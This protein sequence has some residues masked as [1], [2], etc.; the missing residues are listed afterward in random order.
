MSQSTTLTTTVGELTYMTGLGN[1]LASE[2]LP[3][4]LPRDQNTPFE[5]PYGLYAEQINGTPFTMRRELNRRS[6]IYK[7]R[8]SV[9]HSAFEV[10]PHPMLTNDFSNAIASPELMRWNPVPL[11]EAGTVDFVEGL[12]TVGGNGDPTTRDGLAI[13]AYVAGADMVDKAFYNSDGELLIAPEVGTLR[14]QTEFGV[15]QAGPAQFIVIPKGIKFAVTLPDGPSRGFVLEVYNNGGL[16]LPERGPIGANG[17]ADERHFLI[18]TAAYEDREVEGGYTLLTKFGGRL[19]GATQTHSPFDVVA[20]HGTHVPYMY[21][22]AHFNAMGSV[23]FDHPDPSLLTFLNCPRDL[24][25]NSVADVLF[26]MGRWDVAEHTFRPPYL[27]RNAAV[28]F[29]VIVKGSEHSTSGY[30]KGVY[31][32]TPP[33]TGH[34]IAADSY[35]G[36]LEKDPNDLKPERIPDSSLWLMFESCYALKFTPWALEGDNLQENFRSIYANYRSH[37]KPE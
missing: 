24:D 22:V 17:L 23:S 8:P 26:F 27:H 21:D 14:V 32:A 3:G 34:A 35:Q 1:A 31:V 9:Q 16:R 4:A 5:V 33:M 19:W 10:V 13:H 7:L 28:E 11:P 20:W 29:A 2:A 18:P 12:K 25:G 15:L 37:F 30:N 36:A 6:W